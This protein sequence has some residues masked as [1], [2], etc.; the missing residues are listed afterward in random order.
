[1]G[2]GDWFK[3]FK[4]NAGALEEY[5]EG[6]VQPQEAGESQ[7]ARLPPGTPPARLRFA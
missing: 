7:A 2:I 5:R 4:R 1:M 3:R 6:V